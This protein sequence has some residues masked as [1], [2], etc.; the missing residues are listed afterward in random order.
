MSRRFFTVSD[1]TFFIGTVALLNSLR[2]V[3][4]DEELSVLDLGLR[5]DQRARLERYAEVHDPPP[6]LTAHP[7]LA[8]PHPHLLQARGTLVLLD[9][10]LVVVDRLDEP[11]A[12]AEAGAVVLLDDD[13]PYSNYKTPR[14]RW[15]AEWERVLG[16]RRP[17]RRQTYWNSGFLAL[18]TE[19]WPDLL[20]SWARACRA[21]P[22]ELTRRAGAGIE[23]PFWDSDQ[24]ALNAVLMSEVPEEAIA[25]WPQESSDALLHVR[26]EDPVRLVCRHG[27]RRAL[28]LHS[29]GAPKPWQPRASLRVR[30]DAYVR[31]LPRLVLAD[32]DALRLEPRELPLWLRP[33]AAGAAAGRTLDLLNGLARTVVRRTS[34]APRRLLSHVRDRLAGP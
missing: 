3:G 16:L 12:A 20:E 28:V 29:T 13:H 34:G 7:M 24:D 8:K 27:A 4:H 23:S 19:H 2:L 33:G 10:D 5:A 25:T 30:R 9:S 31:L 21:V 22:V 18:A 17:P 6:D 11:L 1:A 26:I 32:D 14:I 15:F